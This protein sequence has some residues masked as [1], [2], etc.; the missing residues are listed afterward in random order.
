MYVIRNIGAEFNNMLHAQHIKLQAAYACIPTQPLSNYV[1]CQLSNFIAC[2]VVA[3]SVVDGDVVA[4]VTAHD[5]VVV[6][7]F[8]DVDVVADVVVD[9][10]AVA[11]AVANIAADVAPIVVA[12][13]GRVFEMRQ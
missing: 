10:V 3:A 7:A 6:A 1:I 13:L 11:V 5:V 2:V 12:A 8:T 4:S 9:V